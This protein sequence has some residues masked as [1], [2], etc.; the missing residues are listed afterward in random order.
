MPSFSDQNRALIPSIEIF[1][2][3]GLKDVM[4]FGGLAGQP[5]AKCG[6]RDPGDNS[7]SNA[8]GTFLM[9][10]TTRKRCVFI[11]DTPCRK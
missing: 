5:T 6:K 9:D 3:N 11:S 4:L 8:F 1:V 10:P 7:A 2:G